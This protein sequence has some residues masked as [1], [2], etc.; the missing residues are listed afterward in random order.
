M[1]G[2]PS[3]VMSKVDF[4][5]PANVIALISVVRLGR[6]GRLMTVALP[7]Q[8]HCAHYCK[9]DAS[10]GCAGTMYKIRTRSIE[11]IN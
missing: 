5:V 10:L 6:V 4:C 3:L 1:N 11:V 2:M 7:L 9:V 8:V